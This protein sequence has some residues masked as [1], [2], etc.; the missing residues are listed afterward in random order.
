MFQCV[1]VSMWTKQSEGSSKA[2][3][4]IVHRRSPVRANASN[5]RDRMFL[6]VRFVLLPVYL[7]S[8]SCVPFC[9]H[10][11]Q[12]TKQPR[13]APEQTQQTEQT[14]TTEQTQ[15]T[16]T[17]Q[18]NNPIA[19]AVAVAVVGAVAVAVVGAVAVSGP[20]AGAVV[21]VVAGAGR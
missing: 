1:N 14:Q 6:Y 15:Q 21:G 5:Y 20:V 19:V 4:Q 2:N 11:I 16:Q 18:P 3:N 8:C 9:V 10:V 7:W 13:G 12:A 17:E